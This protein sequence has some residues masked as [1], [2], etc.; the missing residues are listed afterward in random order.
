MSDTNGQAKPTAA[1]TGLRSRS[2]GQSGMA[3]VSSVL[4]RRPVLKVVGIADDQGVTP[5][6]LRDLHSGF[7]RSA[8]RTG[9]QLPRCPAGGLYGLHQEP[10]PGRMETAPSDLR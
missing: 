6:P 2:P 1:C 9:F 10:G 8:P 5:D 4:T 7:E 3:A